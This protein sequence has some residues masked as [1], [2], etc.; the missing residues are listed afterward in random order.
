M[1]C[2]HFQLPDFF[3]TTVVPLLGHAGNDNIKLLRG[4]AL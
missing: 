2:L 1:S 4:T 3:T